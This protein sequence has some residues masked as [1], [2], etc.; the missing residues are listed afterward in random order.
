M[1]DTASPDTA[2]PDTSCVPAGSE[3]CPCLN[4]GCEGA[5]FCVEETCVQGPQIDIGESRAVLAGLLVPHEVEVEADEFAWSQESGP[6]VEILGGDGLSIGVVVPADTPAG[7]T[8]ALRLDATRNGV[9]LSEVWEIDVIE[10][11]FENGLPKIADPTQLGTTEGLTFGGLGMYVVSTEGFVSLF[12]DN[13]EF[14][15]SYDLGGTPVGADFTDD[16]VIVANAGLGSVQRIDALTGAISVFFDSVGGSPLGAV[17]FPLADGDDL[18]VSTRLDQ[19]VLYYE[20]G[21]D[22]A[23]GSASVFLDDP[24]LVNPNALALGPEG[25]TLYVGT[26]GHVWRVPLIDGGMAG[27]PVDYLDLGDDTGVTYE[28]DGLVFDEGNNLWV[29]CPNAGTLFVARFAGEAA[30]EVARTFDS[31][32]GDLSGFVNLSFGRGDFG[33]EFLYYTNL[34]SGTV[35]RLRVGLSD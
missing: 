4:G 9:T 3:G 2:G 12:G 23:P 10:A 31:A 16:S 28:V 20:G 25:N 17:N 5:L 24:G 29:G 33:N 18:F 7:E 35:G 13:G 19:T 26:V 1:D 6:S 34:G 8:I 30:A 32:P 11:V 22:G 27:E 15:D 21:E 14:V